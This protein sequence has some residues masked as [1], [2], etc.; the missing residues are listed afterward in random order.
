M[1][2]CVV[3]DNNCYRK[4]PYPTNNR[5]S[6]ESLKFKYINI[7]ENCSLGMASPMP[8]QECLDEFYASGTYWESAVSENAT[9]IAHERSQAYWRVQSCVDLVEKKVEVRVLDIGAGHGFI[10]SGFSKNTLTCYDRVE[11]DELLAS[12][13]NEIKHPF[14]SGY[15]KSLDEV[16][17]RKYD[18]VFANHVLEHVANPYDFIEQLVKHLEPNGLVYIEV[19]FMDWKF[20]GDVFPHTLFFTQASI[21]EMAEKLNVKTIKLEVFGINQS[22]Y[23]KINRWLSRLFTLSI[24]V[25]YLAKFVDAY[26]W[27]YRQVNEEGIWLRWIFRL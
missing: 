15:Y 14:E 11:P 7:C 3:C 23:N 2:T 10:G 1:N 17:E 26:I 6:P 12:A 19:P 27:K 18:V 24:R 5:I 22:D 13:F 8:S 4:I 16:G 21:K 25:P 9:Q 20:K